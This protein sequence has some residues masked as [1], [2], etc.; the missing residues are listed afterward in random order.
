MSV[1]KQD[2][3][4]GKYCK[5]NG[6]TLEGRQ[7]MDPG[8]DPVDNERALGDEMVE[9]E[10]EESTENEKEP[11]YMR[12][13]EGGKKAQKKIQYSCS[14]CGKSVGK[15]ACVQCTV[16]QMWCHV[17][18]GERETIDDCGMGFVCPKCKN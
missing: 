1:D 15:S 9:S 17:R 12:Y 13:T 10:C 16:C 7:E 5:D 14:M 11:K 18:C 2:I 3:D 8:E 6:R 4:L